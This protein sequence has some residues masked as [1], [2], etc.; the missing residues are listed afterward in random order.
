MKVIVKTRLGSVK[1]KI[2]SFGNSRY[3]VS[4]TSTDH[5]SANEELLTLLS[6]YFITP[7][8]KMEFRSGLTSND[9]VLEVM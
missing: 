8:S 9:K 2:E 7:L 4:L 5:A 3:M 1:Q 6:K